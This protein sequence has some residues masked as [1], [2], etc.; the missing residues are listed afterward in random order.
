[1]TLSATRRTLAIALA[2]I[3]ILSGPV[4][5]GDVTSG[6]GTRSR[7]DLVLTDR[8][9]PWVAG[10]AI[11]PTPGFVLDVGLQAISRIATPVAW[12]SFSAAANGEG[13]AL[14]WTVTADS[15][16]VGF[17]VEREEGGLDRYVS[18]TS[19]LLPGSTRQFLDADPPDAPEASYRLTAVDRAGRSF[20]SQPIRVTLDRRP[21]TFAVGPPRPNPTALGTSLAVDL[22]A[23]GQVHLLV[24]DVTGRLV[25]E[26]IDTPLPAGRHLLSWD[27]FVSASG[28]SGERAA[29]GVY[30]LRLLAGDRQVVKRVVINR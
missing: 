2:V 13:V 4:R 30:F 18:L 8:L 29:A 16:P 21:I 26:P 22:A 9:G 19:Q 17:S 3:A 23:G 24:F 6:G 25:A 28:M 12:L 5:A 1:V 10:Q 20:T 7:L 27:G 11:G 15:D 14:E